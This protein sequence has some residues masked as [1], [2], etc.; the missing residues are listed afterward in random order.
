MNNLSVIH[1]DSSAVRSL[2]G[3]IRR[4]VPPLPPVLINVVRLDAVLNDSGALNLV[5]AD[6]NEGNQED[7]H[8]LTKKCWERDRKGLA[9]SCSTLANEERV[10][11]K[12]K[13]ARCNELKVSWDWQSW[14]CGRCPA[15]NG[16]PLWRNGIKGQQRLREAQ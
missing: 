1:G 14:H 16:K 13:V 12:R 3:V 2:R 7:P 6:T 10:S 4:A 11:I 15:K 8:S 9:V 5:T